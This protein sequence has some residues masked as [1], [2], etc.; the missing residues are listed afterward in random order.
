MRI[1]GPGMRVAYHTHIYIY[2]GNLPSFVVF[3]SH[4]LEG[5]QAGALEHVRAISRKGLQRLIEN[6]L[7]IA[8]ENDLVL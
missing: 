3:R 5:V 8:G 6:A 2:T 4:G 7:S 1:N